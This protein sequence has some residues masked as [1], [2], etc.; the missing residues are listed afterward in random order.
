MP[1]R[2]PIILIKKRQDPNIIPVGNL[3]RYRELFERGE[4]GLHFKR[5]GE[6]D[7]EVHVAEAEVDAEEEGDEAVGSPAAGFFEG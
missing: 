1:L 3:V 4:L 2:N 7:A 6:G 5:F